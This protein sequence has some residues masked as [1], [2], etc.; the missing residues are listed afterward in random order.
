MSRQ[1]SHRPTIEAVRHLAFRAA[2]MAAAIVISFATNPVKAETPHQTLT[3]RSVDGR[4]IAAE[5]FGHGEKAVLLIGGIHGNEPSGARL[6]EHFQQWLAAR[7]FATFGNT[8]VVVTKAN[9]DGL[10]HGK[11][12]NANGVDLNRNFPSSD[13]GAQR[14]RKGDN[15]G[16][17][18]ASEPETRFILYLIAKFHPCL[19][20]SVHAP[21]QQININGPAMDVAIEMRRHDHFRITRTI[22]YPVPGSLGTYAG[23]ENGIAVVTLELGREGASTTWNHQKEALLAA[24]SNRCH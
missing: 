15:P 13:W 18:P 11:R 8:V 19:I 3:G 1:S 14:R 21:Y 24:V 5:V 20:V 4:T 17:R 7:S 12:K 23:K 16:P 6:V 2:S 9:P 10:A 22:G